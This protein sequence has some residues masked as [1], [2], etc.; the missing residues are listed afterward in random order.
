ML[1]SYE[2]EK[3]LYVRS[4]TY[5]AKMG[6]LLY[7]RVWLL[8]QRLAPLSI[9]TLMGGALLPSPDKL[10]SFPLLYYVDARQLWT[11]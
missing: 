9:P 8:P 11:K 6:Q 3:E 4:S 7:V 10:P 1:V 2:D 5:F